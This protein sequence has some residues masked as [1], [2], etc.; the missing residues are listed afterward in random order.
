MKKDYSSKWKAS[1]QPRKQRKLRANAP[2]HVKHKM[3]SSNL[4][5][6]LRKKYEKRN[7]PIKKGD[8]ILIMRGAFKGKKGKVNEVDTSKMRLS[9][10]GIYRTKKDGTKVNVW[11]VPSNLQ[12]QELNLEDKKR[13]ESIE[14]KATPMKK[15][16]LKVKALPKSE[17]TKEDKEKKQ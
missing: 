2:L 1:K 12:I 6:E 7:F 10:D 11:F 9:I 13:Q 14:R 3:M 15:K 8:S 16:E 5:K 17:E 4:D